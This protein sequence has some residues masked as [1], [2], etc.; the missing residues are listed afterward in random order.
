MSIE[1]NRPCAKTV[2]G[3]V[4]LV[5]SSGEAVKGIVYSS[6]YRVELKLNQFAGTGAALEYQIREEYTREEICIR[7][8]FHIVCVGG[9][10]DL[11]YQF[12]FSQASASGQSFDTLEQFAS[13]AAGSRDEALRIFDAERFAALPFMQDL[14]LVSLYEGLRS[15]NDR[16]LG[17]E[18]FLVA[19]G[20]KKR[21]TLELLDRER[22]YRFQ[23]Q[24]ETEDG[25]QIRRDGWGYLKLSVKA[26]GNFI[27]LDKSTLSEHD[28][29]GDTARLSYRIL[30]SRL[31]MGKNLGRILITSA[32]YTFCIPVTVMKGKCDI[33]T[34]NRRKGEISYMKLFLTEVGFAFYRQR[35]KQ[36]GRETAYQKLKG[37]YS[38][39]PKDSPLY[40]RATLMQA[41]A[42]ARQEPEEGSRLLDL[43]AE[44]VQ[45]DRLEEPGNYC[46]YLYGK[47]LL[48]PG[49]GSR[50]TLAAVLNK[51]DSDQLK[52]PAILV[53]LILTDR[54]RSDHPAMRWEKIREYYRR[55]VRSP[56]LYL[57]AFQ[58]LK[59]DSR[60]LMTLD[61]FTL[62]TLCFG[63]NKGLMSRRLADQT[64]ELAA[65]LK[66]M[67]ERVLT[68]IK[69][70]YKRYRSEALLNS[71]CSLLIKGER[72]E[73]ACF[74]FYEE[75]VKRDLKLTRLYEYYLYTMP[76][77][78]EQPLPRQLLL[79]FS[80]QQPADYEVRARLYLNI[81][82]YKDQMPDIYQS[83]ERE[84]ENFAI[85]QMLKR[86]I[87]RELAQIYSCLIYPEMLDERAGRIFPDLI[88]AREFTCD[89]REITHGILC[90]EERRSEIRFRIYEGKAYVPV[91]GEH[92]QLILQD[93]YGNRYGSVPWR[94]EPLTANRDSL[95]AACWR[96]EPSHSEYFYRRLRLIYETEQVEGE[97]IG[98]LERGLSEKNLRPLFRQKLSAIGIRYYLSVSSQ[99]KCD[100]FINVVS[101]GNLD[102]K[103]RKLLLEL[104]ITKGYYEEAYGI[105]EVYGYRDIRPGR[106]LKLCHYMI[107][108]YGERND[109]LIRLAH[110]LFIE[111]KLDHAI[112][113]Y[114]CQYYNGSSERMFGILTA[115][116]NS[117]VHL[118]DLPER[119]LAQLIFVHNDRWLD[120]VF[121][122]Y[123]EQG[124]IDLVLR[125]AYLVVKA[126]GYIQK[127]WDLLPATTEYMEEKALDPAEP[128]RPGL[129][130]SLAMT[131][132][133][134]GL[135]Q[136]SQ[137]QKDCCRLYLERMVQKGMVFAHFPRLARETG[138]LPWLWHRYYAEYQTSEECDVQI[139]IRVV[140]GEGRFAQAKMIHVFKGIFIYEVTLFYGE[141]AE[142]DIYE[143]GNQEAAASGILTVDPACEEEDRNG[144]TGSRY[145]ALNRM[146]VMAQENDDSLSR[147]MLDYG[148]KEEMIGRVFR[149]L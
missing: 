100:S 127:E 50:T 46:I 29:I 148:K 35:E 95:L 18:E 26:E 80:Y 72:R 133:Y 135:A 109:Y 132:F 126:W 23:D 134:A 120:Q 82:Q 59:E 78:M 125:D 34:V 27:R 12:T 77:Q 38:R 19:A 124:N 16:Q 111:D 74:P 39:I 44:R 53:L 99:E 79:Y 7:G 144:Q 123:R 146:L 140:P 121:A 3:T 5:S 61:D 98:I 103:S 28:F 31:H 2:N 87:S 76:E 131:R 86:R 6:D 130:E 13:F 40:V 81:L 8:R 119:L 69:G 30:G 21:V 37:A 97:N 91:Y 10:Y 85:D 108:R 129:L 114:L 138:C 9:E 117:R 54:L 101:P 52:D 115:A 137:R 149:L 122:V 143:D 90:Y 84:M 14:R 105:V 67:S 1:E 32:L 71:V 112:L 25:I 22:N 68:L 47:T 41:A 55:G 142:Y 33:N 65:G 118:W 57:A 63:A 58:T 75:G 45:A 107:A 128:R 36:D 88:C 92:F 136:L 145:Q 56:W 20:G 60:L 83:Y 96:A 89:H 15:Q 11:P 106:L 43:V 73:K 94:L 93:G 139:R 141:R 113:E 66:G 110:H 4:H 49:E 48:E 62:G 64:A 51:Y 42:A 116:K 70:L 102:G 24:E 147:A 17:M 104:L